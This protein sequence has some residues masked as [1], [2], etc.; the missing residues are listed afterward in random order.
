EGS[1]TITTRDVDGRPVPAELAL[2]VSDEAVT[3]IQ[4]DLA[5]DPREFF[6]GE[7]RYSSVQA[8]ASVQM[9]RYVVLEEEDGKLMEDR[10]REAKHR[11][12]AGA[13]EDLEK[14]EREEELGFLDAGAGAGRTM[15][16][17]APAAVAEAITVTKSAAAVAVPPP[18]PSPPSPQGQIEVRVRS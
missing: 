10:E 14:N 13:K 17:M 1:V 8:N 7:T 11:R 2:A 12:A 18:P 4:K 9:E 15:R 16:M 3:A 6:F 5:A